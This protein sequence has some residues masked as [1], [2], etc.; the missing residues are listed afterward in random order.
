M[1]TVVRAFLQIKRRLFSVLRRSGLPEL[2]TRETVTLL[3]RKAV[4]AMAVFQDL[5]A[6]MLGEVM[7]FL[8]P[9]FGGFHPQPDLRIGKTWNRKPWIVDVFP[10]GGSLVIGGLTRRS[11][12][13]CSHYNSVG[14]KLA[15]LHINNCH[16]FGGFFVDK[17]DESVLVSVN[18]AVHRHSRDQDGKWI[19]TGAVAGGNGRGD[20][21]DQLNCPVGIC[22]D[23]KNKLIVV[24]SPC[25]PVLHVGLLSMLG[26]SP[27]WAVLHVGLF[28]MLG[29]SPC[30]AV[31]HV[32][33]FFMLGCS[34]CWAVLVSALLTTLRGL[35]SC[36]SF[37]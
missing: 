29:C 14:R 18:H 26:C 33:L 4:D 7:E 9:R 21:L 35:Y 28:S 32:G 6:D 13:Y 5:P 12:R 22:L 27:C 23:D 15:D 37:T 3:R 31:L 2:P 34:P 36:V 17:A 10:S 24:C 25:W 16:T 8:K 20:R 1:T 19:D 11:K 30:W